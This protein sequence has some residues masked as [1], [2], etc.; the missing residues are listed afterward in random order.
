MFA[1]QILKIMKKQLSIFVVCGL[2][3]STIQVCNAQKGDRRMQ[4]YMDIM[5]TAKDAST[6]KNLASEYENITV[7]EPKNWLSAYYAAFTNA[8]YAMRVDDVP[9][10]NIFLARALTYAI[11]ADSLKPNESEIYVMRGMILGMQISIDPELGASIGPEAMEYMKKARELNS[12]NPRVWLELGQMTMYTPEQ[13]G[14]GKK[15]AEKQLKTA[16]DKYKTFKNT[17]PL[18]PHWGQDRLKV[19][20]EEVKTK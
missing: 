11:K 19:L 17:N 6:W 5:D 8:I 20:L 2:L 7:K 16:Q 1:K 3:L 15:S 4:R 14:G 10:K 13:Y 18:W 9:S 12:E